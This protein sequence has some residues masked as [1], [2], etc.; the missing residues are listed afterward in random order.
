MDGRNRYENLARQVSAIGAVKRGL[1][2]T[3]PAECPGGSAIVLA[4]LHHHGDMRMGRVSELM[5][6][7]MSVSSRHVAHTVDR[8]WVERLPDP[9]D[10]RSRILHLTHAGEDM[11]A[12]LD[13]RLTDMLARTLVEWS[14]DDVELL[15]D[16]L[17]RLRDSFGDCRAHHA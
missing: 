7:D 15:T 8:G 1:A 12:V 16:L 11:L 13:R 4:L 6:V 9:A 2:R 10:R 3:L 14:D 17:A 5:A